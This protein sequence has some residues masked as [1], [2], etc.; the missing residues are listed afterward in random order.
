VNTGPRRLLLAGAAA[1]P[2]F[3]VSS[4]LQAALRTGFEGRWAPRRLAMFGFAA[5]LA[6]G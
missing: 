3:V 6:A 2:F 4:L 5:I 1:G